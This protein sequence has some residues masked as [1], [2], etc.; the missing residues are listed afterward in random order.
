MDPPSV[1]WEGFHSIDLLQDSDKWRVLANSVMK[2][3]DKRKARYF[4][5]NEGTKFFKT[6]VLCEVI[7]WLVH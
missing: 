6:T 1:E 2:L 5:T 7:S 3:W 4:L